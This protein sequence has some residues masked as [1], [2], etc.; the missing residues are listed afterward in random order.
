MLSPVLGRGKLE[1][2]G[3]SVTDF[4]KLSPYEFVS[5]LSASELQWGAATEGVFRLRQPT[6][7]FCFV[8]KDGF[9]LELYQLNVV[10][11]CSHICWC[12]GGII[13]A[14]ACMVASSA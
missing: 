8:A 5:L 13:V 3:E 10:H 4:F 6:V 7:G 11:Y 12:G 2:A 14:L 9:G 1:L